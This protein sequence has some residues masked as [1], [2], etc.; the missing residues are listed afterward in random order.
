MAQPVTIRFGKCKIEL[1]DGESPE[2][3]ARPCGFTELDFTRNKQLNESLIPDCDDPDAPVTVGTDVA[4]IGFSMSGTGLVA[5]EA[6]PLWDDFYES[7]E[8]RNVKLTLLFDTPV[9]YTGKAHL[10]TLVIGASSGQ[11]ATIQVTL[12]GDGAITRS[13]SL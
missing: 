10:E 3:F 8:S 6:L 13:P 7:N 2:V 5:E 4:S 11:R 1:G 12:R 9:S